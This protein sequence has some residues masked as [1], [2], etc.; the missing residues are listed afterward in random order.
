VRL[1]ESFVAQAR[2]KLIGFLD[3]V[4]RQAP[5]QGLSTE[6]EALSKLIT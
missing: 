6:S 3:Q 4:Q 5:E 2:A 1:G